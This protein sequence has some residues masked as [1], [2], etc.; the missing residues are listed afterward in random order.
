MICSSTESNTRFIA[1]LVLGAAGDAI[2]FR[3]GKWEFLKDGLRLFADMKQRYGSI[4]NINVSDHASWKVSDDTV[5]FLATAESLL[6]SHKSKQVNFHEKMT[7]MAKYYYSCVTKDMDG[8]AP[9]LKCISSLSILKGQ[10]ERWNAL[11]YDRAGGG[12]GGSMRSQPCGLIY[13]GEKN[14]EEL[15]R[16]SIESGRLTHNHATGYMGAF[17]SAL[18]T[19]YAIENIPPREWGYLFITKDYPLALNY[20]K[21]S[22]RDLPQTTNDMEKFKTKF[23]QYLKER[24]IENGNTD[25]KF[26]SSYGIPEREEFYKKWSYDGWAGASGDDSVIIAYDALLGSN[27]DWEEFV[28]RGVLHGG[29]NDSTGCIGATWFGAYYGFPDKKFEK[30][31]KNIEYYDRIVKVANE[32]YLQNQKL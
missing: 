25:P 12:C 7:T 10:F 17:V 28:H 13:S 4:E 22:Q 29:D 14:R 11:P 32:L 15:V 9:G 2:G 27:G 24:G 31:W 26:P 16:T 5:M 19:S 20:V 3:N 21:F 6:E 18:F 30:N 1:A 8:R 23:T